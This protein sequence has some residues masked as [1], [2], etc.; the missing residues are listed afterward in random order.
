[1]TAA[2]RRRAE[3]TEQATRLLAQ[4]LPEL[5]EETARHAVEQSAKN[6]PGC[7]ALLDHLQHHRDALRSGSSQV[8]SPLV[9]LAH[10]L[11][12]AGTDGVVL[13]GCG[14]CGKVTPDLRSWPGPGLAC[15]SCYQD[16][17]RQPCATCGTTDRVAARGPHGPVC[18]RCYNDPARHEECAGCGRAR[19]V[20]YR[21]AE[22][23]PW[24]APCYPAPQRPCSQCGETRV[25]TAITPSG[26]VCRC[27]YAQPP[28][29]C[30]RCG[31][32]REI[33]V[34]A[35][36][37]TPDLCS[38]CHQG[39]VGRVLPV[40]AARTSAGTPGRQAD[41]PPLLLP[42][43]GSVRVL[44]PA[45]PDH[46][47]VGDRGGLPQLLSADPGQ[48]GAMPR[49]RAAPRADQPRPRRAAGLRGLRWPRG[50]VSVPQVR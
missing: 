45:R 38:S 12:A 27:C 30:G 50:E 33:A 2:A 9:R 35:R 24:C 34:R 3:L 40:R 31:R 5:S 36:D 43:T 44:R 25:T 23:Q 16:S 48:P 42:A 13:P 22:G 10:A 6:V 29:Q 8:P 11:S 32:I 39:P 47:P 18:R 7:T 26:P 41:L 4:L 19:R 1:M 49:L 15:Q 37:G 46:R 21:D 28:R 20:A 14:G 17:R